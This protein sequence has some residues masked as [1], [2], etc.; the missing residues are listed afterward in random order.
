MSTAPCRPLHPLSL[1]AT[2]VVVPRHADLGCSELCSEQSCTGHLGSRGGRFPTAPL[3]PSADAHIFP[4]RFMHPPPASHPL[5]PVG[6]SCVHSADLIKRLT[7]CFC[8]LAHCIQ[9]CPA[10]P[11]VSTMASAMPQASR[12][13]LC[14]RFTMLHA[15]VAGERCAPLFCLRCSVRTP[16][17]LF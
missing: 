5:S 17:L 6:D 16:Y 12:P 11:P 7:S 2:A 8:L 9:I 13:R 10:P 3:V 14:C 1:L 4:L 15:S